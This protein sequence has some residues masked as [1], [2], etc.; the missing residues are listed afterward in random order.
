MPKTSKVGLQ[1][2]GAV[3][4]TAALLGV[5]GYDEI[6][7]YHRDSPAPQVRHVTQGQAAALGNAKW[8]LLDVAA[9]AHQPQD[10]PDRVILQIELEAT[11][12]NAEGK[13]YTSS[14]P[15]FYMA[16]KSGRTWLAQAT[17]TPKE[18]LPGVPGR[19][20]LLSAVPTE[21]VN[22]AELMLWPSEYEGRLEQGPVLRFDR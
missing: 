14:L 15:G 2:F 21:L 11:A 5:K 10:T 9:M 1:L 17:K 18:L 8:R 4:L 20:T 6:T 3:A 16:D 7:R 13:Y 22:Q 19:F 12:L